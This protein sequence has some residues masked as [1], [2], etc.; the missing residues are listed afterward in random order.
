MRSSTA[1]PRRPP[2]RTRVRVRRRRPVARRRGLDRRSATRLAPPAAVVVLTAS[3]ARSIT[4][5]SIRRAIESGRLGRR[6]QA[7]VER[8]DLQLTCGT[9]SVGQPRNGMQGLRTRRGTAGPQGARSR[10]IRSCSDRDRPDARS[11]RARELRRRAEQDAIDDRQRLLESVRW[12]RTA[13][14]EGLQQARQGREH[15]I[16]ERP[17]H[18]HALARGG[19]DCGIKQ[20]R[21]GRTCLCP[22]QR[23]QHALGPL[24][25]RQ[26]FEVEFEVVA[27]DH[28][29]CASTIRNARPLLQKHQ[30]PSARTAPSTDARHAWRSD[31]SHATTTAGTDPS[32]HVA[33]NTTR[34][35]SSSRAAMPKP[36]IRNK[37]ATT[38]S[39]MVRTLEAGPTDWWRVWPHASSVAARCGGGGAAPG[40]V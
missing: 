10:S 32:P 2:A 39:T 12:C 3:T 1:E 30:R 40:S 8:R 28:V 38:A 23:P 29:C 7:A 13:S 15:A 37:G 21:R 34:D 18:G 16:T 33:T 14:G 4:R 6:E 22:H 9:A 20:W 25:Y 24:V 35:G 17:A 11:A 26:K 19:D 31:S 5:S 36:S 27:G